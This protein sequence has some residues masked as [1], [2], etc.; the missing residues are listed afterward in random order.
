MKALWFVV[1]VA[2]CSAG[3]DDGTNPGIDCSRE[4]ASI[5]DGGDLAEA[6]RGLPDLP[7]AYDA[8]GSVDACPDTARPAEHTA[9]VS[10]EV[11]RDT[12][13]GVDVGTPAEVSRDTMP[14][15]D[16]RTPAEVSHDTTPGVDGGGLDSQ[17][18]DLGEDAE[19]CPNPN[20]VNV[21][22]SCMLCGTLG[23]FCCRG[24]I[25]STGGSC[26]NN[27]CKGAI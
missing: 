3:K 4:T 22:G 7:R 14:G 5:F 21:E 11:S 20:T 13:P 10:A 27:V 15:V 23:N 12:T 9:D 18:V 16:V 1:F 17:A 8:G 2:A 6:T 19:L 26:V 24:N 25:C